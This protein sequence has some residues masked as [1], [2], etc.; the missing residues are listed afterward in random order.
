[1]YLPEAPS[2]ERLSVARPR[3][4]HAAVARYPSTG[5]N[6]PAPVL[7]NTYPLAVANHPEHLS[8]SAVQLKA[9]N[10][11]IA[12]LG[13]DLG[14]AFSRRPRR[15]QLSTGA[16]V[17]VDAAT[18]D[19]KIVVEAYAR[20]GKLKGAQPKKIAQDILKLA[21]LKKE[22]DREETRT[23]IAFASTAARDSIAGWLREAAYAFGVELMTV[24]VSDELRAE[25][26]SAQARQVMVNLDLVADDLG[27]SDDQS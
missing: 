13:A 11:I 7:A 25:I 23:I 14:V 17:E 10:E 1:M 22:R 24:S 8:N 18:E 21:L 9:A 20:Q 5:I 26:L 16:N 15:I 12:A 6:T 3:P 27:I 19:E 2:R 4:G